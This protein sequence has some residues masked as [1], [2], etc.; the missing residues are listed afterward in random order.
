V[1]FIANVAD[2]DLFTYAAN[3]HD[4]QPM[5]FRPNSSIISI[6][7]FGLATL[8]LLSDGTVLRQG[9]FNGQ[10]HVAPV[11]ISVLHGIHV[12]DMA[13]AGNRAV[14]KSHNFFNMYG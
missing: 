2:R 7:K 6:V 14:C 4:L 12:Y 9:Y 10:N 3:S 1:G 13:V 8:F 5:Q 11:I